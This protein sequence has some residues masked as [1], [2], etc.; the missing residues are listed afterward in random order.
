MKKSLL[1]HSINRFAKE[2]SEIWH[3]AGDEALFGELLKDLM[4]ANPGWSASYA[5]DELKKSRQE[6][7]DKEIKQT[8]AFLAIDL[9]RLGALQK[10]SA[11]EEEQEWR[12]VLPMKVDSVPT[13][14]PRLYRTKATTLVPY[15]EFDLAET[16]HPL[17]LVDV[18]LGPGSE[19]VTSIEATRS[20][21]YSEGLTKITPRLSKAPFRAW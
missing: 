19:P 13:K 10:H 18:I 16:G 14:H 4:I 9:L 2:A 17:P 1:A 11:F 15:I 21:L 12:L 5:G 3:Q 20:F 8:A 6:W 7:M